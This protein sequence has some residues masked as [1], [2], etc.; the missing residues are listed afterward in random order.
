MFKRVVLSGGAVPALSF[1][2]SL[3]YLEHVGL[4]PGVDTFVGSSAGS[5]VGLLTVLG[6][7][8]HDSCKFFM[9]TGV[10][11]HTLTELDVFESLFGQ[12]TCLDTLGLD[13]GSHWLAF[14]GDAVQSKL[15]CRDVTFGD[16]A[17]ITG[18]VFVVCVTNL[19]KVRREYL[20]VDTVPDMSVVLA[21]RMSLSIPIM[22]VPIVYQGSLYVDGSLLDNLPVASFVGAVS[23]PATTLVL[24]IRAVPPSPTCCASSLPSPFQYLNLLLGAVVDH[25]QKHNGNDMTELSGR[26]DI[27]RV[28]VVVPGSDSL[29]CGFDLRSLAFQITQDKLDSLV[30]LGYSAARDT[31]EPMLLSDAYDA[32]SKR[33]VSDRSS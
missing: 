4:L 29:T 26:S 28:G 6:Y 25:A 5:V 32:R 21:V 14:L 33:D 11:T 7:S 1:F 15:G 8:P 13:D 10:C 27:T 18:K 31:I 2:G 16:L 20:S 17:R 23:G 24:Y 19:T 12:Q 3:Q 30:R 9:S 22:Y